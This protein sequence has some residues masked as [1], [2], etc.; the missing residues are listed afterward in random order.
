MKWQYTMMVFVISTNMAIFML[1]MAGCPYVMGFNATISP[2]ELA[3]K[4]DINE[5]YGGWS[6]NPLFD[7]VGFTID[8]LKF[9]L[10]GLRTLIL[11]LPD[12]FANFGAPAWISWPMYGAWAFTWYMVF[13][14]IVRGLGGI[15]G[16]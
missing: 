6:G 11:G 14:E 2:T 1:S 15:S 12:L 8:A 9:I 7:Y 4:F 10:F 13:A 16:D 5:T 3:G